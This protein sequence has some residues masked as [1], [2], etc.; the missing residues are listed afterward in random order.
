M[1]TWPE[2]QTL[3]K[4]SYES[5]GLSLVRVQLNFDCW[6]GGVPRHVLERPSLLSDESRDE[7]LVLAA[8]KSASLDQVTWT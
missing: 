3:W 1:W 4:H 7:E 8:I 6:Y 2:I 5:L